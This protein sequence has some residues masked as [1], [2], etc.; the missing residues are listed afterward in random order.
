MAEHRH[1]ITWTLQSFCFHFTFRLEWETATELENVGFNLYRS[2]EVGSEYVKIN[3]T[4][5]PSQSPGSTFGAVYTW[6]DEDI[7]P[8]R[9]YF[10][11][12][13]DVSIS[14]SSTLHGPLDTTLSAVPNA[15]HLQSLGAQGMTNFV[16]LSILV[17]LGGL[18]LV[19]RK[20]HSQ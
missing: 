9:T 5:I 16:A 11:K 4:L 6:L 14:G 7:P 17:T 19:R 3:D 10:Y 8:G 18:T 15:V 1:R 2:T 12:L 20:C 13:E